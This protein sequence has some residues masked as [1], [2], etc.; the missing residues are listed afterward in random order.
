MAAVLYIII[1][2]MMAAQQCVLGIHVLVVCSDHVSLLQTGEV[3]KVSRSVSLMVELS[4]VGQL[5]LVV[6]SGGV[7]YT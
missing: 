1:V 5:Q 3:E 7:P 2:S 4:G 6:H